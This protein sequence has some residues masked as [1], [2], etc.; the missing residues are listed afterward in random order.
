MFSSD[1]MASE[2]DAGN[3]QT[4]EPQ[5]EKKQDENQKIKELLNQDS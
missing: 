1:K 4:E 5:E 3:Q 2:R